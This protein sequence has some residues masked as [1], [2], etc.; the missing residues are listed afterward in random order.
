MKKRSARL[1]TGSP[2]P[3]I[4]LWVVLV[5]LIAGYPLMRVMLDLIRGISE[6]APEDA[7]AF[8]PRLLGL[9]VVW[10]VLIGALSSA[11]GWIGAWA[12][13]GWRAWWTPVLIVP[14][15][16]PSSLAFSGFGLLRGPGTTIG[17]WLAM[18]PS[19]RPIFASKILAIVGLALWSSPLAQLIIASR[20]RALDPSSLE[21]SRLVGGGALGWFRLRFGMSLRHALLAVGAVALLMLGSAVPLHLAQMETYA[22]RVWLELDA[23]SVSDRW[24]VIASAWP[25]FL[26]ALSASLIVV[27][28]LRQ[29]PAWM[30]GSG[31][32][33]ACVGRV[34][35]LLALVV[36]ILAVVV[37]GVLFALDLESVS[38]I[39]T[40]W[41]SQMESAGNAWLVAGS[42]AVS[43]LVMTSCVW[44]GL[45][46]GG[47]ARCVTLTGV[48]LL[49]FLAL[50][51]GVVTGMLVGSA[52]RGVGAVSDSW[53]IVL[54]AHMARFGAVPALVGVL[55]AWSEPRE[56]R[57]LRT[58]SGA[59][60]VL[61]WFGTV[62]LR[63]WPVIVLASVACAAFSLHEIESAIVVSPPGMDSLARSMLNLLHFQRYEHLAGL[64]LI[65]IALGTLPVL[66]MSGIWWLWFRTHDHD[67]ANR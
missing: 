60:G 29:R 8:N 13:R 25:L 45:G 67:G 30:R 50:V 63:S 39:S 42:L 23:T 36:P 66:M 14:I 26:I 43:C 20:V 33:E 16:M 65:V 49:L 1:L 27:W 12:S 6:G 62:G 31:G 11:L 28:H 4:A 19:W 47:A 5:L 44:I 54:L 7:W 48:A 51:P 21:A 18:G 46:G 41:Q 64:S 34:P 57:D 32:V 52:W 59:T 17:D 22:T 3:A 9:S 35:T 37:P 61:G 40:L 2:W 38:T 10:A 53:L 56:D 24:R 55:L 58:I 15:L